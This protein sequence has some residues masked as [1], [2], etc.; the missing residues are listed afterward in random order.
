MLNWRNILLKKR[1][2][3]IG[4]MAAIAGIAAAIA[5]IS[6]GIADKDYSIGQQKLTEGGQDEQMLV[7]AMLANDQGNYDT[8]NYLFSQVSGYD[9]NKSYTKGEIIDY[10]QHRIP[11]VYLAATNTFID[12]DS[13]REISDGF[14]ALA[15][16]TSAVIVAYAEFTRPKES[17]T[18]RLG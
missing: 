4:I 10:Y 16:G 2:R 5:G 9:A 1:D 17:Q 14:V 13:Y 18:A 3:N 15:A 12:G 6:G 11:R 7:L 8:A